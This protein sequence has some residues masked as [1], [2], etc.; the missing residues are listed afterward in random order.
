MEWCQDHLTRRYCRR[1]YENERKPTLTQCSECY[2]WSCQTDLKQCVGRPLPVVPLPSKGTS[3]SHATEAAKATRPQH[4]PKFEPCRAC[5]A[6]SKSPWLR[7]GNWP[8]W[9]AGGVVCNACSPKGGRACNRGHKWVC[10][11]CMTCWFV[12]VCPRCETPFCDKCEGI[13]RCISCGVST[14][15]SNCAKDVSEDPDAKLDRDTP[16]PPKSF[17]WECAG[18][19][20]N[21]CVDCEVKKCGYGCDNCSANV[22]D[23]CHSR[24]GCTG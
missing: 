3:A 9:S 4:P 6:D 20:G 23:E 14:I 19:G 21:L 16:M 2:S 8:C 17:N 5:S 10:D 7:C 13:Q 15:C 18:C 22:C 11:E 12:W 1:C 24:D